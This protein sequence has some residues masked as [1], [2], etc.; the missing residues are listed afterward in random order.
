[1]QE[2]LVKLKAVART[3]I[4]ITAAET[5]DRSEMIT[6]WRHYEPSNPLNLGDPV[7]PS[8]LKIWRDYITLTA[9]SPEYRQPHRA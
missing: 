4:D 6:W 2:H 3:T 5:R 7:I 9:S 8:S 1:M